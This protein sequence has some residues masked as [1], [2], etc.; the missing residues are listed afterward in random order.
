LRIEE[1]RHEPRIFFNDNENEKVELLKEL[2]A[3]QRFPWTPSF[4]CLDFQAA[5]DKVRHE[6]ARGPTLVFV[7]QNGMK[8]MTK[9]VFETLVQSGTT[10][11]L[12]FTA[13]SFKLR[14][15]DLLAPEIRIPENLAIGGDFRSS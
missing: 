1:R 4:E 7:D 5:F 13:S 8:H 12:F 6:F 14:F 11:F 9:T 10:D 15:R 3:E 2:C